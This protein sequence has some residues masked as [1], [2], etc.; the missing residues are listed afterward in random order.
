MLTCTHTHD[1]THTPHTT[2]HAPEG[3]HLK[4]YYQHQYLASLPSPQFNNP[5]VP[6]APPDGVIIHRKYRDDSDTL[7][8]DVRCR[9]STRQAQARRTH[10]PGF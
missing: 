9:S 2:A 7:V 4:A 3:P 6:H 1:S 5:Q 8:Y 10:L